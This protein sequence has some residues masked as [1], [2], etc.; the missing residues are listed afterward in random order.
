MIKKIPSEAI[1]PGMY[2]HDLNVDWMNH[3]F[4]RNQFVIEGDEA[5]AKIIA[6][7]VREVYIDTARGL[8]M[9]DAPTVEEVNAE[10]DAQL[11]KMAEEPSP[12]IKVSFAEEMTRARKIHSQAS[13]A[14]RTVMRDIRL[15]QAIH[16]EG[17]AQV[18]E[19]ITDSV[20]RNS[21]ALVGLS[22]IK[23]KDEYTFLHSVSVC[24]LM[25]TFAQ[26]LGLDRDLIRLAGTGGL[27][28]DTGKMKV[29]NEILNKPGRLT[30]AEFAIM[31]SHPEAGWQILKDIDGMED[32]PLDI[33]LHH[34]ERMD[35]TG[36]PHK[37]PGDQISRMA[38]MAAVVDV[39]D[40]ITSDRCYHKGMPAPEG[41]RKLWEW[42]KF[43]FNPELVQAFMRTVG[44]YPVGTLVRLESGRLAVV[45]D[46]NDAA[47]LQ[48]KVKVIFS[49]K[50]NT[51]ITPQVV[52]LARPMGKGGAD[53][54]VGHENPE[55]WQISV[56][57]FLFEAS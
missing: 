1:R 49:T 18:V 19:D 9:A 7:G 29:P 11:L 46:Q 43:H 35:G 4:V 23:N 20:L 24:T 34:H 32:I 48:P 22:G 31:Q 57:R 17:V 37:L 44:I 53:K 42:S 15:G 52:D 36:Y 28:H 3:P 5:I 25:V 47:M 14:V 27:L 50:S 30:E 51:Y 40:A 41:L 38:Q 45:I 56:A 2:I 26:S 10:L 6:T 33:T 16:L 8:D 39:Y 13:N 55:K 21:G 12:I 54:I